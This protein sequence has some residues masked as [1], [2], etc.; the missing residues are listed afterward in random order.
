[1]GKILI[2]DD[3]EM[4]RKSVK[5]YL[6][7]DDY[8]VITA[9][10]GQKGIEAFLEERPDVVL[11]DL[12]MPGMDGLS[13]L[14]AIKKIDE[15]AEVIVVTGHGDLDA[16]VESLKLKASN[17]LLKPVDIED[18]EM[19]VDRSMEKRNLKRRI[20]KTDMFNRSIM[21][22]A[23]NFCI[24]TCDYDGN[25]IS[26]N[27]GASLILGYTEEDAIGRMHISN[28]FPE[29]AVESGILEKIADTILINK[30]YEEEIYLKRKNGAIFPAAFNT[31]H[32][33]DE[34]DTFIGMLTIAQDITERKHAEKELKAAKDAFET[35]SRVKSEFLANM[36]HEI[37]TPMNGVIG[38][39]DLTLNTRLTDEQRQN[40]EIVKSSADNLMN[41]IDDIL[42]F[43][44]VEAGRLEIEKID[45]GLCATIDSII[46][47]M[48]FKTESKGLELISYIDHLVPDAV[49]GDPGRLR[50]IIINL[51]GNS[52]KFTHE[53]EILFMVK[54]AEELP[55][56]V[57][58]LFSVS[59]T[60]IGIPEDRREAIFKSFIQAD[61]S[62]TRKYGG[63]GLGTTISKQLVEL[64]GGKIWIEDS[65]LSID[66]HQTAANIQQSKRGSGIT[67][68]FS[69][70]LGL[71]KNHLQKNKDA[72]IR[73]N[74]AQ[75]NLKGLKV[76]VVD[77]NKLNSRILSTMLENWGIVSDT[78]HKGEDAL[79]AIK[80]SLGNNSPYALIFLD[81][82][83]PGIDGFFVAKQIQKNGWLKHTH[84][85]MLTSIAKKGH[86][87]MCKKLRI[88]SYMPKP[89]N[90][91]LLF[92]MIVQTLAQKK[93]APDNRK[94]QNL[95]TRHT[96]KEERGKLNILLAEDNKV[97]Q[98]VAKKI[99]EKHGHSV[100][101]VDNGRL[102]VETLE[103]ECY[104]LVL[105]DIQM[106]VMGGIEAT[107]IIRSAK[108]GTCNTEKQPS[109][110]CI[111]I[112]AVTAHSMKGDKKK[113]IEAGM[114]DYVS[115]PIKPV[116]LF[117]V[118]DRMVNR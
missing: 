114:N 23:T 107:K 14:K 100:T 99:L 35:A 68:L 41:I 22:A 76:L 80:V 17:F 52:V 24:I 19:V 60:G 115:K 15:D 94:K 96:I 104:D 34:N 53:G 39:T 31:S 93:E 55:D 48:V 101:V 1:M 97:N 90:Q 6:E 106:P 43:S 88:S 91:S 78:A 70:V 30:K 72:T 33:N 62:T 11:T 73:Y 8:Q 54:V 38:M 16:A 36:S 110:P 118:I 51:L 47:Q 58:L 82:N 65:P 40:L 44:K 9:A 81:Y 37:R 71:Q 21:D 3:E 117:D 27:R 7:M 112:I 66:D 83:M 85:I 92:D 95:I 57:K 29:D 5:R 50:Q 69:I 12:K 56:S 59:D 74:D 45:F 20:K 113:F 32:L 61:G 77:D 26:W 103:K 13:V 2:I 28:I 84:I 79:E 46:K 86:A 42:D 87:A 67:F 10:D 63:T 111:P 18:L 105:M 4:I 49:I 89:V 75:I 108:C 102:A 64:M 109:N 116:E 98:M 25:I